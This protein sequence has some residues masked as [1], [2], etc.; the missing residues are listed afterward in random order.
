LTTKNAKNV[1]QISEKE[2]FTVIEITSQMTIWCNELLKNNKNAE[3]TAKKLVKNSHRKKNIPLVFFLLN[4]FNMQHDIPYPPKE[5]NRLYSD[6]L[7]FLHETN[8]EKYYSDPDLDIID[9]RYLSE[10]INFINKNF[11]V[12]RLIRGKNKLNKYKSSLSNNLK[13]RIEFP[14]NGYI[15]LCMVS[16]ELVKLKKIFEK[17]EIIFIIKK[18]IQTNKIIRKCIEF[19][20]L[21]FLY[22][23]RLS[24][25]NK[26]LIKLLSSANPGIKV[27]YRI[28]ESSKKLLN[29]NKIMLKKYAE[30]GAHLL[31]DN[32]CY[33]IFR[34]MII[35][36]LIK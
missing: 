2:L 5:L 18:F 13:K 20:L 21:I 24:N 9:S 34:F 30:I 35:V 12:F 1:I 3:L 7:R 23:L 29:I 31:I 25:D 32:N 36:L 19:I 15:S 4:S 26:L 28:I 14:D 16:D 6:N 11:K 10:I 33:E 27:D 17:Q 8:C 22:V